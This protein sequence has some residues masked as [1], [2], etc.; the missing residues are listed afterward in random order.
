VD[1]LAARDPSLVG[2][3]DPHHFADAPNSFLHSLQ[4]RAPAFRISVLLEN[5]RSI[6]AG[7]ASD[8]NLSA[9]A[10]V[11][12]HKM[13]D[14]GNLFQLLDRREITIGQIAEQIFIL[15]GEI[16]NVIRTRPIRDKSIELM[17]LTLEIATKDL[18]DLIA[19]RLRTGG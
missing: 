19:Q 8:L 15:A 13:Y 5:L 4:R 10:R 11:L 17:G 1:T 7:L 3:S 14:V 16:D 6:S 18:I 12:A 2:I 9:G